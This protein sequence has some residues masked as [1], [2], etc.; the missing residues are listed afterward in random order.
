MQICMNESNFALPEE[1]I[2]SN[3]Y[4]SVELF[5]PPAQFQTFSWVFIVV[6]F[7]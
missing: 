7:I 2:T 1:T 5:F 6:N 4:E 3:F